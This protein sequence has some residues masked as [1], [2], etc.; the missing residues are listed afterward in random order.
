MIVCRAER[1]LTGEA[2]RKISS[3]CNVPQD[4]VIECRTKKSIYE[5]PSA[6]A[7]EGTAELIGRR[8]GLGLKDPDDDPFLKVLKHHFQPTNGSVKV[9]IVGKYTGHNDAYMS[10]H[11]SLTHAAMGNSVSIDVD[12]VDST[13]AAETLDISLFDGILVP[14]GFGDRGIEGKIEMI[15]RARE[16]NIPFFGICLGMQCAVSEFARHVLKLPEANSEEF[17]PETA[18]PVVHLMD[19]QKDVDDKGATM[20]LGLYKAHLRTHSKIAK[21]YGEDQIEER[22]RHR[23]EVNNEYRVRL[24]KAGLIPSA[25][26][27]DQKLVEAVELEGHPWFVGVQYHPE[28]RSRPTKPHPLFYGF[29]EAMVKNRDL[30]AAKKKKSSK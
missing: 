26:S 25:I 16:G 8:L 30:P 27:P 12:Y 3:F 22:H 14:G 29:V 11:E 17:A 5:V 18:D 13:E 15:R 7:Q 6:L 9:A 19:A 4:M 28:F 21:L 10:I 2:K 1:P 20:R 23:Y 24:E